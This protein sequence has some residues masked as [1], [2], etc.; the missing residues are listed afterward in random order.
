MLAAAA[1]RARGIAALRERFPFRNHPAR[2][3]FAHVD[4]FF[5]STRDARCNGKR[6]HASISA[7]EPAKLAHPLPDAPTAATIAAQQLSTISK[8]GT[9]VDV[10]D[11][12][13]LFP[14]VTFSRHFIF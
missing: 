14:A 4:A 10:L 11:I 1:R 12:Y 13:G 9:V 5:A 8:S 6:L 3:A 7:L 2:R